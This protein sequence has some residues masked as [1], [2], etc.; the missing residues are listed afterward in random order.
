MLFPF[1]L[2]RFNSFKMHDGRLWRLQRRDG[3]CIFY[4]VTRGCRIYHHRPLACMLYPYVI[5]RKGGKINFRLDS[6]CPQAEQAGTPELPEPIR[7][8]L[9]RSSELFWNDYNAGQP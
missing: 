2:E 6:Q 7:R 8:D 1:E 3:I 4:S 5:V 9:E